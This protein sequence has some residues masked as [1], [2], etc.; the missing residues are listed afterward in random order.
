MTGVGTVLSDNPRLNVRG[1]AVPRQPA[2]V[3]LDRRLRTPPQ[4]ALMQRAEGG[5]VCIYT[6]AD[7]LADAQGRQ[8]ALALEAA[9]AEVR[10]WPLADAQGSSAA[11]SGPQAGAQALRAVLQ[12]LAHSGVNELHV[13]AGA[14]LNGALLQAGLVDELLIYLAPRLLGPGLALAELPTLPHLG[15]ALQWQHLDAQPCGDDLRLRFQALL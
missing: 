4:A 10:P 7:T 14:V 3:V 15:Q 1:H 11:G 9:G 2:R 6:L 12:D 13:E 5:P 8:R